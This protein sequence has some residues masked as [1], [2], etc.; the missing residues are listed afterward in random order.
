MKNRIGD[1]RNHLFDAL[2]RLGNKELTPEQ[3]KQE[4]EKSK[5]ISTVAQ[6]I[7]ESAKVEVLYADIV[8]YTGKKMSQFMED[9]EEEKPDRLSGIYTNLPSPLGIASG[10]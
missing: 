4:I 6:V 9:V 5:A 3:L 8:G 10:E 7:V 1:L 2:E